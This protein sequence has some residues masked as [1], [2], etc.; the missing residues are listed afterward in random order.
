MPAP[1]TSMLCHYRYDAI[2]RLIGQEL[3]DMPPLQRF[4][5]RSR[6]VNEIH[7]ALRDTIFQHDNWLLAQQQQQGTDH[8]I[9][10]LATDQQR[11][12]L[13]TLTTNHPIH[14]I[15]YSPYG[16]RRVTG[17]WLSLTGFN[18]ERPD[19]LTGHYLLG[20]GYRAFNPV[21]MRFNSPDSLSPFEEGGLNAYAY[22]LGNPVDRVDPTGHFSFGA[23]RFLI[24]GLAVAGIGSGIAGSITQNEVLLYA[25][26][27]LS[28]AAFTGVNVR[29]FVGS[30]TAKIS[31]TQ[32]LS[33]NHKRVYLAQQNLSDNRG[34]R[35]IINAH[36]NGAQVGGYYP[37]Q[38][39]NAVLKKY[40][41]FH[42]KFTNVKLM[43]CHGADGGIYSYGQQL[44]NS[45]NK[46]VKAYEGVMTAWG[47]IDLKSRI[48]K[49]TTTS[50]TTTK[51]EGVH[52]KYNPV[53]FNPQI[54][55]S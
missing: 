52:Y 8:H 22:A 1:R 32:P 29:P 44:A 18:G 2:D 7:G 35:L 42:E 38:L 48:F 34:K 21:L 40:P 19:P 28:L 41:D 12:V 20:N 26:V 11:S 55:S 4:Y 16:H 10:L 3:S 45:L 6:L 47:P 50:T 49:L 14:H 54:R 24:G 5:C 37:Q 30:S 23:A 13:N 43:S 53:I 33:A 17:G 9:A 51:Y 25:G 39:A 15:A 27:A 31:H 46:P 36:G